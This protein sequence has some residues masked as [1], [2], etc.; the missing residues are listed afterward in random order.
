M[1]RR[2]ANL[3]T[4]IV[5]RSQ[6]DRG[7]MIRFVLDPEKQVIP[8]IKQNL[9]GRGIWVTAQREMIL[10]ALKKKLFARGFK[11]QVSVDGNLAEITETLLEKNLGG[12]I[13]MARKAG[14]LSTGM[15]KVEEQ[16]RGGK[17][18][19]VIQATDG[20]ADG[21]DK[22]ARL[23][24]RQDTE[25]Q[26]FE[27]STKEQLDQLTGGVNTAHVALKASGITGQIEAALFKLENF[28]G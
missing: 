22:L 5:S 17:A 6:K 20:S 12:L 21:K 4:C 16:V 2:E 28:N 3:R 1:A 9:P 24:K 26:L 8:D 27:F 15:A 7:E 25:V 19:V 13:L 11:E 10:N 18:S 14:V 23:A